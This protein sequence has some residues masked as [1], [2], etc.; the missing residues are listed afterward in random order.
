MLKPNKETPEEEGPREDVDEG[1]KGPKKG[2]VR[3]VLTILPV[4][5]LPAA[6]G[7]AIA[8]SQYAR[9]AETAA[10]TGIEYGGLQRG[11]KEKSVR[12]G[13]F[14]TISDLLINPAGTGGKG[15]LVVT[16]GL[17]TRSSSVIAEIQ[18]KDIVIRDA[19]LQLLG[20]QTQ[21]KLA[22]IELRSELKDEIVHKL[23][24]ILQKGEVD[25][26]YFTQFLLQ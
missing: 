10:A 20:E 16:I 12:Y 8:Y 18:Q 22:A 13:H 26:L 6:I 25:R 11:E 19:I 2:A 1:G 15:F 21:E 17:E 24:Q 14:I 3:L 9:I 7:A 5:L 4:L 23:N